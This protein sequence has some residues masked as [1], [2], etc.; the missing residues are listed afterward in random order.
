MKATELNCS[1]LCAGVPHGIIQE[2]ACA[3]FGMYYTRVHG[4]IRHRIYQKPFPL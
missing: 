1:L 3:V 4:N 2:R